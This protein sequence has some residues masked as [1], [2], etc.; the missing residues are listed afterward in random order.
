MKLWKG[1]VNRVRKKREGYFEGGLSK[2]FLSHF[3]K[4]V[5]L[6]S[7]AGR[8]KHKRKRDQRCRISPAP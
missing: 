3:I 2:Y 8:R 1:D 7:L 4:P 5:K 6:L